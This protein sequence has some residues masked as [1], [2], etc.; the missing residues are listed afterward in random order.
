MRYCIALVYLSGAYNTNSH[1]PY[2]FSK[3][4]DFHVMLARN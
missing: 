1:I 2:F 4:F 3:L